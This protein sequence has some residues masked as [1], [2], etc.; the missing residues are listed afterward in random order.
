MLVMCCLLVQIQGQDL[1]GEDSS[2]VRL[3]PGREQVAEQVNLVVF[4]G[5]WVID[6][7]DTAPVRNYYRWGEGRGTGEY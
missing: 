7:Y 1:T 2:G 3:P 5:L 4:S 6:N